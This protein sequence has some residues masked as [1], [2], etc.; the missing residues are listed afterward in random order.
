MLVFVPL[1]LT[2][3]VS[4]FDESV[5]VVSPRGYTINWYFLILD[6]FARP[7]VNSLVVSGLSVSASVCLGVAAAIGLHRYASRASGW[8][9]A[10]LLSPLTLPGIAIGVGVYM[11]AVLCEIVTGFRLINSF[12][13]LVAAHML[14]T[15]PWIVR[16]CLVSLASHDRAIEE[17]AASLGARPFTV[18]WRITLP[19]IRPGIIAGTLFAFIISFENLDLALF[20]AGPGTTTLPVATLGYLEYRVD[21]LIAAL[22]VVQIVLIG[23]VLVVLDRF[24]NLGKAIR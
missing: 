23:L 5:I 10:L 17:A 4:F 24:I 3:Y 21:P 16:P 19:V 20:L 1:V 7:L 13:L 2:V 18:I 22:A 14:I 6:T 12:A 15:I 9:N 8:A 11:F